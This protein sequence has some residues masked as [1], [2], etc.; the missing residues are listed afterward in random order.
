M[1]LACKKCGVIDAP[2]IRQNGPHKTAFCKSCGAYIKHLSSP[3]RDDF[4]LFFG[5]YKDRN[6]KSMLA[7]PRERDYLVWLFDKATTIKDWQK[8]ILQQHLKL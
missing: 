2:E 4:T 3:D 5:M 7:D 6:I 8:K 1:E